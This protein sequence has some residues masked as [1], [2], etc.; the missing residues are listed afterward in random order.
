MPSVPVPYV[1]PALPDE[2]THRVRP[3]LS[4]LDCGRPS[5][6]RGVPSIESKPEEFRGW[7]RKDWES[8]ISRANHYTQDGQATRS[9]SVA[10]GTV[11][12]ALRHAS[13]EKN[14]RRGTCIYTHRGLPCS[15]V[16]KESACNAGDP[17]LIPGSG[18]SP[19]GGNGNPLQDSCLEIPMD[20]GAWQATAPGIASATRL[21][22]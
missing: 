13:L 6:G 19:G 7:G 4:Q 22:D 20:R 16:G 5:R 21:S 14:V 15:S 18:R 11:S 12:S 17:G 10:Q 9:C 2:S 8:G 1:A 3:R